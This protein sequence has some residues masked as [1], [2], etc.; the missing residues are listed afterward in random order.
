MYFLD[1]DTESTDRS[2]CLTA[3]QRHV[4]DTESTGRSPCHTAT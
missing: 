4:D 3:T 1:D 2:L